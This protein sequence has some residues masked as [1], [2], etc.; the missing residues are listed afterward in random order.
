MAESR[1][2]NDTGVQNEPLMPDVPN[3][4]PEGDVMRQTASIGGD[5]EAPL[6]NVTRYPDATG[7]LVETAYPGQDAAIDGTPQQSRIGTHWPDGH[8]SP[9]MEDRVDAD[10]GLHPVSDDMGPRHSNGGVVGATDARSE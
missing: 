1:D 4:Q 2:R 5:G 9:G 7:D 10:D 6:L 8:V 3:P